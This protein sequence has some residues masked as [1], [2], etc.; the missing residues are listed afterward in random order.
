[1]NHL[2]RSRKNRMIGGVAG[3]IAEYFDVDVAV[4]RLLWVLSTLF[5]GGGVLAYIIAWIIIPEL[6]EDSVQTT[7]ESQNQPVNYEKPPQTELSPEQERI[8]DRRRSAGG[9]LLI[10]LGVLFLAHELAPF[11][12]SRFIWPVLLI[13]VGVFILA[14]GWEG[15]RP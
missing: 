5:A 1:M 8:R 4:V 10:G 11:H 6:P 14:R 2:Y 3:G 9:L 13:T 15:N 7:V 12:F